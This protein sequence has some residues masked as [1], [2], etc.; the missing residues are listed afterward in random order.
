[1]HQSSESRTSS[2]RTLAGRLLRA[3][4]FLPVRG[5]EATFG[6]EGR[7]GSRVIRM[8]TTLANT[9]CTVSSV[10][11]NGSRSGSGP[12]PKPAGAVCDDKR[13]PGSV[14]AYPTVHLSVTAADDADGADANGTFRLG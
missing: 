2:T 6:R 4:T 9:V 3:L 8:Q 1:M 13:R 14:G 11:D 5:I 10:R 7:A 12:P